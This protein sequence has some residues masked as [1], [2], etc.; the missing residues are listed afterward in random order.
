MEK[1]S[2]VSK[3]INWQSEIAAIAGPFD[4][5]RKSWLSRAAH[6]A[7]VT[8]RQ[9]KSLWYGQITNP[10]HQV[11]ASVL[12]AADQARLNEARRDAAQLAAIYRSTATALANIDPHFHRGSID[13]LVEAARVLGGS[14]RT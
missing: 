12:S 1:V 14:D 13:A 8:A 5:N 6:R 11:A 9:M 3:A 10:R 4:G 2:R 7:G